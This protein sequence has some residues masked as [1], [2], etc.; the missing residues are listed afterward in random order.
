[1]RDHQWMVWTGVAVL[2]LLLLVW[3]PVE[4][5]RQFWGI[6]LIAASIV[7]GVEALRRQMLRE[8]S[9]PSTPTPAA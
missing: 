7:I 6:V 5:T 1:M 9:P 4:A 3:S 2:F 8:S